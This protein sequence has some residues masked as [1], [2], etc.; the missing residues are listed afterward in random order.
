[1]GRVEAV[2][3]EVKKSLGKNIAMFILTKGMCKLQ[4]EDTYTRE[5]LYCNY[6]V[7]D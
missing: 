4:T 2:D 7:G 1:M 3:R 6:V 5:G